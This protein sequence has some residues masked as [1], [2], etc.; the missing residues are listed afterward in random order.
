MK[1]LQVMVHGSAHGYAGG[2]QKVMVELGNSLS[3]R[4]HEVTSIYR[5]RSRTFFNHLERSI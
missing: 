1:I 4:G 5:A 2:T 3:Y